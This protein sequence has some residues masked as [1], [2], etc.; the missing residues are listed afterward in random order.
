MSVHRHPRRRKRS[1]I[2]AGLTTA[3]RHPGHLAENPNNAK[4]HVAPA[5]ARLHSFTENESDRIAS[6]RRDYRP[7]AVTTPLDFDSLGRTLPE[8]RHTSSTYTV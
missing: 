5:T 1:P 6:A 8:S 3:Y 4:R 7:L 2:T